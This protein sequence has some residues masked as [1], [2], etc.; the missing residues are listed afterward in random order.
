MAPAERRAQLVRCA[1]GVFAANGFGNAGHAQVAEAAGVS[2]PTVFLYLPNRQALVDA[3]LDVVEE[4]FLRMIAHVIATERGAAARLRGIVH[5]YAEGIDRD[6]DY[7]QVFLCWGAVTH[8]ESWPRYV[9][10]Q[11]RVLAVFEN[12]IR[13]GITEGEVSAGTDP[14]LGAHL[15]AGAATMIAQMKRRRRSPAQV[16]AFIDALVQGALVER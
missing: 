15:V 4:Y 2:T 9:A 6:P 12:V 14:V 10:F 16:D 13:D 8:T 11:D 7:V 3:V 1:V 5:A